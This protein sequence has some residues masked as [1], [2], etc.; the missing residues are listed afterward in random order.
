[1][2]WVDVS[3]RTASL[4]LIRAACLASTICRGP[5]PCRVKLNPD[6]SSLAHQ[7]RLIR[8]TLDRTNA[9]NVSLYDSEAVRFFKVTLEAL[10]FLQQNSVDAE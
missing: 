4:V 3:E 1:M 5:D 7:L 8:F 9:T 2:V 6:A 10:H